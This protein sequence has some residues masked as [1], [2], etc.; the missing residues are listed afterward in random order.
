MCKGA[1][2][3]DQDCAQDI[4]TQDLLQIA[5]ANGWQRCFSCRR[6]VE[7]EHGCNHIKRSS[8]TYVATDGRL[9]PARRGTRSDSTL[10]LI[11]L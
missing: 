10:A 3:K 11:P 5:A 7:L 4:L 1:E 6:I 2:H 9:A 8:A